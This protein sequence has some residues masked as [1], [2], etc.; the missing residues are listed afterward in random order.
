MTIEL[1]IANALFGV[2][3]MLF[4]VVLRM[5]NSRISS[6]KEEIESQQEKFEKAVVRISNLESSHATHSGIA[7]TKL[8]AFKELFDEKLKPINSRLDHQDA[9]IKHLSDHI[10]SLKRSVQNVQIQVT[11]LVENLDSITARSSTKLK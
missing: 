8:S 6:Q 4:G 11:L 1:W 2:A 3:L 9:T 5:L 10:E 7:D